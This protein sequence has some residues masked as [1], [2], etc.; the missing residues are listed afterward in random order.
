MPDTEV[1]IDCES[2]VTPAA[3]DDRFLKNSTW[4]VVSALA[5]V[6]VGIVLSPYIVRLFGAERFGIW[7]LVFAIL[8]Y[9]WLF[10][11]GLTPAI[12]NLL[13]RYL[14]RKQTVQI[15]EVINTASCYF[16][17][18]SCLIF[19]ITA[20]AT[21][22]IVKLFRVPDKHRMEFTGLIAMTGFSWGL[23]IVHQMYVAALD[24]FQRF[25]LSSRVSGVIVLCRSASYLL[26]LK[27][28]GGLM[29][30]GAVY[31]IYQVVGALLHARN[32]ASVFPSLR[33]SGRFVKWRM[34]EHI[35]HYGVP[36]F[37]ANGAG[38]LVNQSAPLIIG[39]YLPTAFVGFFA[40]PTK[41]VQ[42]VTDVVSRIGLVT[43][44]RAAELDAKANRAG[45]AVLATETNRYCFAVYMPILIVLGLFGRQLLR[46]WLGLQFEAN[47][48]PLLT[49]LVF[50]SAFVL[51]GQFNSAAVLFGL[52]EHR[53][54]ARLL[55]CEG[56]LSL[57]TLVVVVPRFGILGATFVVSGLMIALRGIAT[58]I[59]LCRTLG[60]SFLRYMSAIYCRPAMTAFLVLA[61]V[62]LVQRL[63]V[64]GTTWTQLA[65]IALG[66]TL[67][68]AS[69]AVM[70]CLTPI[71]RRLVLSLIL[72]GRSTADSPTP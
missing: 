72:R 42:N 4:S 7:S 71:H 9:L 39:H 45:I 33:F 21:P 15:N 10:D 2:K 62:V 29:E 60:I 66:T 16:M 48:G 6:F 57:A 50:S 52:G 17:V 44:S 31:V 19:V 61:L 35:L 68:Y 1:R 23:C 12:A 63:G 28:G 54:Y 18:I 47:S 5:N 46:L 26:V 56:L 22:M 59:I 25:D 11:L 14:A 41:L 34:F 30:V 20:T 55:T 53:S 24:A 3:V 37:F 13:T 64:R 58:P 8:D 32:F 38:L 70:T 65:V 40:L 36:A 67:V 43:R 69:I 51:G 49:P 27:A